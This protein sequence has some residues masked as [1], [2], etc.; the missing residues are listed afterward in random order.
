M[1]GSSN[2]GLK[3]SQQPIKK[4]LTQANRAAEQVKASVRGYATTIMNHQLQAGS[5]PGLRERSKSEHA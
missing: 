2:L 4:Q 5:K 3:Q 1:E